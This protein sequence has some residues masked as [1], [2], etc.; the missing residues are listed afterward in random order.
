MNPNLTEILVILDA[1]VSMSTMAEEAAS[2]LNDFIADQAKQPGECVVTIVQ[3]NS[4]NP[5][6]EIVQRISA[7]DAPKI[8]AGSNY[9]VGGLT[10]LRQCICQ[11]VDKLGATLTLEAEH[12]R[13]GKVIVVI[14]TDGL[15]NASNVEYTQ[16]E[17]NRRVTHQ[18]QAYSW[19]FVFLGKNICSAEEGAKLGVKGKKTSDFR[20]IGAALQVT[21]GKLSTFRDSGDAEVLNFTAQDRDIMAGDVKREVYATLYGTREQAIGRL[22]HEDSS[23]EPFLP[24]EEI[25][26]TD[27]ADVKNPE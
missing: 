20:S 27:R 18:E 8:V 22:H 25:E 21:S 17:V 13:P 10:P 9:H 7:I 6:N 24:P 3:F 12:A 11:G 2:G 4:N 5:Y 15:E 19:Q 16:A 26:V 14:I 23:L 1:S